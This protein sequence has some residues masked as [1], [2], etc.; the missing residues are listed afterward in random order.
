MLTQFCSQI[1]WTNSRDGWQ[2]VNY[3]VS[4]QA[5]LGQ[6]RRQEGLRTSSV[7]ERKVQGIGEHTSAI[8][9][10]ICA[11]LVDHEVRAVKSKEFP[12]LLSTRVLD[13]R[14]RPCEK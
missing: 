2:A 8:E 7:K 6:G 3:S 11:T 4:I 10:A 1:P 5:V 12:L 14:I 13:G 9:D